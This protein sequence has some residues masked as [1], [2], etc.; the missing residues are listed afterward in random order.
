MGGSGGGFVLSV[1]K[2]PER[3]LSGMG[4][5]AAGEVGTVRGGGRGRFFP[6]EGTESVRYNPG[7]QANRA[8]APNGY[9]NSLGD[10]PTINFVYGGGGGV[11]L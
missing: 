2:E 3:C 4:G 1:L 6:T 8:L 9:N 10:Q 7:R 5:G 11:L